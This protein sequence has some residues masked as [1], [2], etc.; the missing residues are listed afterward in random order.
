MDDK[1][2]DKKRVLTPPSEWADGMKPKSSSEAEEIDE[3]TDW[4]EDDDFEVPPESE[5]SSDAEPSAGQEP[6]A[7]EEPLAGEAPES[8][9]SSTSDADAILT[10]HGEAQAEKSSSSKLPWAVA[11]AGFVI[12]GGMGGL[13]LDAQETAKAEIAELK[14]TIRSMKRAENQQTNQDSGLM[15]DNKALQQQ[16]AALQQQNN[17]LF[18]ENE[19]LKNREA[20]RAERAISAS[21]K[22]ESATPAASPS[23]Q[24]EVETTAPPSQTGGIWFVNLESHKSQAVANERLALLRTKFRN[25][26]LSIASANVNGQTYY[27]VRA[28]GYASKASATAA[29]K[30][31][32]QTLKDGPFWVGKDG[33]KVSQ[34]PAKTAAPAKKQVA[35]QAQP[36]APKPTAR[37]T[38]PKQPI[39]LRSLPMRDNWFVF[40]DTYDSGQRADEVISTLNDQGLDAKV[41]VESRSGELFYRV[42]IVGIDSEATGNTIV[43]QLKADEFKNARLRK[44]VN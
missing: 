17:Q 36:T 14:D 39:R 33:E 43:A 12:A 38:V 44:T 15:A 19:A 23:P 4:L 28:T 5:R 24:M 3:S 41:A 40:V 1:D 25:I 8:E 2:D 30:S 16:I 7:G 26:N 20:E 11:I 22:A 32:A 35:K 21:T 42:Q 9:P 27:R 34:M 29:S 37:Q 31:M 18:D 13:W 10:D 6:A